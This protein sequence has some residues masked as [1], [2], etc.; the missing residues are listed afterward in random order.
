MA[1]S[2]RTEAYTRRMFRT[3]AAIVLMCVLLDL[4][5]APARID[6]TGTDGPVFDLA[7]SPNDEML[8]SAGYKQV[9][10]WRMDS[11]AP[12]LTFRGH[13]EL[14]RSV[15]WSPDG[16]LIASTGDDGVAHVWKSKSGEIVATLRTGPARAIRWSPDG[17]RL[18]VGSTSGRLQLWNVASGAILHEVRLQTVISTVA[19]AP[20]GRSL[21][22]GGVNGLATI[23]SADTEKLLAR[24]RSS[25]TER[26][27]VNGTTWSPAGAVFATAHGAL[28]DGVLRLWRPDGALI[29]TLSN[30]GGFLRGIQWSPDAQWLAAA[31]EDGNVR[32]WNVESGDVALTLPTD[33][34]PVWS[35]AWS[36]DGRRLAAGNTG[37]AGPP[38]V[39]GTVSVWLTP[40]PLLPANR[41]SRS[42]RETDRSLL[43]RAL[44]ATDAVRELVP[45]ATTFTDAGAAGIVLRLESPFAN[46]E[47][48]FIRADLKSLGIG[49][50]QSLQLR[51]RKTTVSMPIGAGWEDAPAGDWIAYFSFEGRLVA[52]RNG[53][54]AG[55]TSGCQPGDA[56]FISR[57]PQ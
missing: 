4:A 15:A 6:F 24:F 21:A 35:L 16:A 1:S 18:A 28:G 44:T 30:G 56:V 31:G 2:N 26:S 29:R 20:D 47:T 42:A 40:V 14:V 52:A 49:P 7:W 46:L 25:G 50:G 51:C 33:S 12:L 13:T 53:R 48:S 11:P 27:D 55:E 45:V 19:W 9:H 17:R 3:H 32:I 54:S 10:V 37:S 22:A 39:G 38:R 36:S 57:V 41:R 8:A 34:K 23:W 43:A 5:A